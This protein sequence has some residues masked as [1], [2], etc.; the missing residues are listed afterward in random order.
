MR[1]LPEDVFYELLDGRAEDAS[2]L[3][4]RAITP[5]FLVQD[6]DTFYGPIKKSDPGTAMPAPEMETVAYP[7]EGLSGETHTILCV[8]AELEARIRAMRPAARPA[9]PTIVSCT[10]MGPPDIN[11]RSKSFTLTA[12]F[13]MSLW[14]TNVTS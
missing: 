14:S 4:A 5:R 7:V 1:S 8:K 11:S 6:G 9:V 10:P 13:A 2:Q 12:P 3:A